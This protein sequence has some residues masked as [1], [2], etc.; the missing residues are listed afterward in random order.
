MP[1]ANNYSKDWKTQS[2]ISI[3]PVKMSLGKYFFYCFTNDI[4][5]NIEKVKKEYI[6]SF[7]EKEVNATNTLNS[8]TEWVLNELNKPI[9]ACYNEK[10]AK[11][12]SEKLAKQEAERVQNEINAKIIAEVKAT[13]KLSYTITNCDNENLSTQLDKLL[14]QLADKYQSKLGLPV[15]ADDYGFFQD[16][17]NFSVVEL[18]CGLCEFTAFIGTDI[19][20]FTFN[21]HSS[22][23]T[24]A[25]KEIDSA[26][27][28]Y[29]KTGKI[30]QKAGKKPALKIADNSN[31]KA[32][33]S[34]EAIALAALAKELKSTYTVKPTERSPLER[35]VSDM[36]RVVSVN[37]QLI[38]IAV[39]KFD[40]KS[41]EGGTIKTFTVGQ[42]VGSVDIALPKVMLSEILEAIGN[43]GLSDITFSQKETNLIINHPKGHYELVGLSSDELITLFY[44]DD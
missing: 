17:S 43:T 23:N 41:D 6:I 33:R 19:V 44:P 11:E 39:D 31:K 35:M 18:E 32:K 20:Q 9:L 3:K 8:A 34:K 21:G 1:R 16:F 38:V 2:Y 27:A 37:G 13:V 29:I 28:R 42:T 12:E 30:K 14:S 15:K 24:A 10:L 26:I 7:N 25:I 5:V 40:R 4:R 22:V 36:V